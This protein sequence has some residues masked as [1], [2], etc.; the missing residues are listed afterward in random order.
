MLIF[1]IDPGP[2]SSGWCIWDTDGDPGRV[3]ESGDEANHD[4]ARRVTQASVAYLCGDGWAS[5][6]VHHL[7]IEQVMSYGRPVG[8]TVFDTVFWSGWFAR[9]WT[10]D[11]SKVHRIPFIDVKMAIC[12]DSRAKESHV[13]QAVRDMF[14]QTGGGAR[15]EIGTTGQP[16]PLYGVSGH[17]RSA[18]ALA[19]TLG[20][21]IGC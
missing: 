14:P 8:A 1:A 3:V 15:P 9:S 21:A 10:G 13:W 4:L 20:K 16:G 6:A 12:H 2:T 17:A 7:V 11:V 5:D 19:I 18:L